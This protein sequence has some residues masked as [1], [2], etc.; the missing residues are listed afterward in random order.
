[1]TSPS[2][3]EE[4]SKFFIFCGTEL[5]ETIIFFR[6]EAAAAVVIEVVRGVAYSRG[7]DDDD[8]GWLAAC[9]VAQG[10]GVDAS[11]RK[12]VSKSF[13]DSGEKVE[14]HHRV[15]AWGSSSGCPASHRI[16]GGESRGD[17]F[18]SVPAVR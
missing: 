14:C 6:A 4:S 13:D 10:L 11:H 2:P 9:R 16:S 15:A 3:P 8:D 5:L 17:A 7:G 12:L 18:L 1:M